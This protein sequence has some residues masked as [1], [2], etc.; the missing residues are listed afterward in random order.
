MYTF[1]W[2]RGDRIEQV[3]AFEVEHPR[4]E[5]DGV[6][7]TNRSSTAICTFSGLKR[8]HVP[9]ERLKRRTTPVFSS[10]AILIDVPFAVR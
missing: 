10:Q 7:T 8:A 4:P 2:E 9:V 6:R 3:L 5:V 1:T